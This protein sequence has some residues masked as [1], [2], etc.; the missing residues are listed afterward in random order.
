MGNYHIESPSFS[1]KALHELVHC[2]STA[3]GITGSYFPEVGCACV[4]VKP[5]T[6]AQHANKTET[7][8]FK[9]QVSVGPPP[10][11]LCTGFS[12]VAGEHDRPLTYRDS[13]NTQ[14]H[15]QSQLLDGAGL[16][17]CCRQFLQQ[18]RHAEMLN[19]HCQRVW[20]LTG[21]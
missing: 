20:L 19:T 21:N 17:A 1:G 15:Y 10:S 16:P 8:K 6:E 14:R 4:C 18:R 5:V 3:M 7:I 13:K 9:S 2:V 12:P 11:D